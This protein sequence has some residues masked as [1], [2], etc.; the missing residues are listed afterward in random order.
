V[1][2]RSWML[3][4]A[5]VALLVGTAAVVQSAE[6]TPTFKLLR[7]ALALR[8]GQQDRQADGAAELEGF[9]ALLRRQEMTVRESQ[10]LLSRIA[11]LLEERRRRA[12]EPARKATDRAGQWFS[13]S[14]ILS[15]ARPRDQPASSTDGTASRA[16][17]FRSRPS[18]D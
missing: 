15:S 9:R 17:G 10:A 6:D 3:L 11:G 14:I 5:L 1:S 18:F 12:S 4:V 16:L 8:G 13:P 2:W 7:Q